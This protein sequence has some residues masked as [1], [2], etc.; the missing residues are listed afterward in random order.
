LDW[1]ETSAPGFCRCTT[2]PGFREHGLMVLQI[3]N[4]LIAAIVGFP[5]PGSSNNAACRP[6]FSTAV[7]RVRG[8]FSLSKD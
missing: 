6:S 7:V 5:D 4:D 1:T 2:R 3:E 8:S